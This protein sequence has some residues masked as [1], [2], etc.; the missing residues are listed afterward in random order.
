MLV[1]PCNLIYLRYSAIHFGL[2]FH[3]HWEIGF[4][5]LF[6]FVFA[7]VS[8]ASRV[9]CAIDIGWFALASTFAPWT[10]FSLAWNVSI[11]GCSAVI[12][13]SYSHGLLLLWFARECLAEDF[14]VC[15]FGLVL[16]DQLN[17]LPLLLFSFPTKPEIGNWLGRAL[18]LMWRTSRI[19]TWY[20]WDE[21]RDNAVLNCDR[22][23]I[24][25]WK[26]LYQIMKTI[27][28]PCKILCEMSIRKVERLK[29]KAFP[30]F[31]NSLQLLPLMLLFVLE[32]IAICYS[33]IHLITF[34]IN[35]P[36]LF[37]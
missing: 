23:I 5:C 1:R 36:S 24:I 37:H 26:H 2:L 9:L 32:H 11:L 3:L 34:A 33:K 18:W 28:E 21:G 30:I 6:L 17:E 13:G 20:L 31:S 14:V 7:F 27:Y 10:A 29:M 22:L 25:I 15:P 16:P 12:V 4:V 8:I 35:N 19:D